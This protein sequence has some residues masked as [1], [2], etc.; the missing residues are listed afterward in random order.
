MVRLTCCVNIK[1]EL[2][3]E[4]VAEIVSAHL[5][6]GVQFTGRDQYVR[7]EVPAVY[8]AEYILG[9]RFLLCGAPDEEGYYLEV[10]D[11]HE[12]MKGLTAAQMRESLV[13]ISSDIVRL[14]Q[15]VGS[16]RTTLPERQASV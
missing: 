4:D 3:L 6:G 16:I 5:L 12:S 8:S 14:L 2:P 9:C 11:H 15:S 1:S 7:D 10:L 13:D